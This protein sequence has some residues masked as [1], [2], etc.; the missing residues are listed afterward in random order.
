MIKEQARVLELDEKLALEGLAKLLPTRKDR[1]E[2]FKIAKQIAEADE[3]SDKR[4]NAMLDRIRRIL[5]LDN[6]SCAES[7][8]ENSGS[9]RTKPNPLGR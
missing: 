1:I 7:D 4:E 2:A 6:V 3:K 9:R 5:G 8:C